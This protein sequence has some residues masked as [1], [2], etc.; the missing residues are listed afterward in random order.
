MCKKTAIWILAGFVSLT[1]A[2]TGARADNEKGTAVV[3][4]KVVFEGEAADPKPL[5]KM[6]ADAV[7]SKAHAKPQADQG[8]IVYKKDGNTIPFVFV[9]VKSG[10]KGKYDAPAEPVTLDQSGC[11]Y[12]PHVLGMVA[13]QTIQI[14]NSDPTNHNIHSLAKK[15]PQFNFAQPNAGM[16]KELKTG[17]TFNKPEI[18]VKIK[19][20]VHAWMSSFIGV[21]THPFFDVTKNHENDGGD[22]TKRGTFELKNLPAGEYE[23]EAWH[24]N[25]GTV[26]QKVTIKDGETKE[27]EFK[28]GPKKSGDASQKMK[29]IIVKENGELANQTNAGK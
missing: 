24:E 21:C 19:C 4:G 16:V 8:T 23:L 1:L 25:F 5:P 2:T 17:D 28:M 13:G 9:Y 11:M 18:M 29:E 12:H 15:N 6:D 3:K 7:C 10:L 14:K 20:D 27:I 26:T 22:K